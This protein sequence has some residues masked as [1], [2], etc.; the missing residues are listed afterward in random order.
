MG[1]LNVHEYGSPPLQ[2]EAISCRKDAQMA[3]AGVGEMNPGGAE[4]GVQLER[5]QPVV[6]LWGG[7]QGSRAAAPGRKKRQK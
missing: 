6:S 3:S 2:L 5:E 1:A 7:N 4:A